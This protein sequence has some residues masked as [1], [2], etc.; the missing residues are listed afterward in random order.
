MASNRF[1]FH[2]PRDD[3]D[4][5]DDLDPNQ[6]PPFASFFFGGP[7][8]NPAG[9]QPGAAGGPAGSL[10][11]IFSQFGQMFTGMGQAME[12]QEPG[13]PVNYEIAE[14]VARQTFGR[15]QTI[16]AAQ[17]KVAQE[18]V[19]LAELWLS[20]TTDI[21]A[22]GAVVECWNEIQWM[23]RTLPTWKRLV[24]PIEARM[25]EAQLEQ[26][27]E[28]AREFVGPIMAMMG[29]MSS[30]S[31]GLRVG[32]A[33][34]ELG[35]AVLSGNDM[36]LPVAPKHMVALLP[37]HILQAADQLHLDRRDVMVYVAA[38]EAARQ[39]LF[40]HVPW[41]VE[42]IVSSVE[43]YAQG[44]TIDTSHIE[45]AARSLNLESGD[46][47]DIQEALQSFQS[48]DLSPKIRSRNAAATARLETLLALVEGWV[49]FVVEDALVDRIPATRVVIEAW[50]R[51]RATGGSADKAFE[52][53][54]GIEIRTPRIQ[55]A[56]EL[57]RRITVAVGSQ[58][59]D[60]VWDHPDFLPDAD[61]IEKPAAF[62][63][64]LLDAAEG[65][66]FDPIAEINKLEAMLASGAS[67][68]DIDGG[69]TNNTAADS[70]TAQPADDDTDKDHTGKDDID[71]TSDER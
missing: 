29:R 51:R 65:D 16:P 18:A 63:D 20:G 48:I 36:G 62:I 59:R 40:T 52:A 1:G 69:S 26:M 34:A 70:D 9:F 35:Q 13:E 7:G 31:A 38:R 58:R 68:E 44:L 23:E 55:Q 4:D 49:D 28:Q 21:P 47:Q 50:Q 46:P 66:E 25:N 10:G 32:E 67:L 5:N 54:G 27:P 3:D 71:D 24:T 14:K 53:I 15:Q 43:E 30:H 64:Q 42:Q 2:P 8:F 22:S 19:N 45:D 12:Q 57:W 60:Q 17:V 33:L 41:L 61:D 56:T 37:A 39:R 6:Q 11:D